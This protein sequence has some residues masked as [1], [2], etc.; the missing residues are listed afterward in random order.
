MRGILEEVVR[1][2]RKLRLRYGSQRGRM[3]ILR[4]MGVR[5]G[6][7]CRIYTTNFGSEPWLIRIGNRVCISNDVTFVNHHLNWPFQEKYD[8]LTG[9]DTIDIRD[10]CQVGVG[11]LLL[12]GI[13]IGPNSMVGAGSV[14]T[15]DVPPNCVA[16]GNPAKV[17][18]TMDEYEA[19]CRARHIAI[20]NDRRAA[21][22][23]LEQHFWGNA[24]VVDSPRLDSR[25]ASPAVEPV[26]DAG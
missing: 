9:F 19:K 8:S 25:G 22:H 21:R 7:G 18:C 14:V 2:G 17:V 5:L 6:K 4:Q 3:R 10:N 16:A 26:R 15:K 11:V 20:P 12:P 23:I 24:H 1:L 13:T